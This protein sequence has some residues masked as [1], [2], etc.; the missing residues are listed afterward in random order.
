MLFRSTDEEENK[1]TNFAKQAGMDW[2]VGMGSN[3][4]NAYGVRGIPH[5]FI[6]KAGKIVWEGHPMSGLEEKLAELTK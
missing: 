2:L 3:T 5:A 4:A 1:V 6:V